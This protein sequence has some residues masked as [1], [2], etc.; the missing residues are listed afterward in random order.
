MKKMV[1]AGLLCLT[2]VIL[3]ACY[4]QQLTEESNNKTENQSYVETEQNPTFAFSKQ[5]R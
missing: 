5:D 3:S 1:I 4:S 2:T